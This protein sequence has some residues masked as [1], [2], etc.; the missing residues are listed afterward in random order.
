MEHIIQLCEQL[1]ESARDL[2]L[3]VVA[4][5]ESEYLSPEEV[6]AVA[7]TSSYFV[8]NSALQEAVL[9]DAQPILGEAGVEDAQAAASLMAMNTIYFRFRHMIGKE[10][11]VQMR[12]GLRMNRI[13]S[14]LTSKRQFEMTALACAALSGCEACLQTHEA[15]LIQEGCSDLQINDAVRIA[16]TIQGVAVA[17]EL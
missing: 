6:W 12:A 2:R 1:P 15:N 8:R 17:L 16:A 10:A 14:P 3:N 11:Y 13:M 4:V 9:T 5:L 7:L